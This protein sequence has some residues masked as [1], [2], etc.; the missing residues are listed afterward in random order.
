MVAQVVQM[1]VEAGNQISLPRVAI[2]TEEE[3]AQAVRMADAMEV[4]TTWSQ[5]TI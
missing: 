3:E 5:E 2:W 1:E 4:L